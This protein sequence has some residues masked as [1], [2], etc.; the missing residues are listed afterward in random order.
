MGTGISKNQDMGGIPPGLTRKQSTGS[1]H[2]NGFKAQRLALLATVRM[3]GNSESLWPEPRSERHPWKKLLQEAESSVQ[4]QKEERGTVTDIENEP[5]FRSLMDGYISAKNMT[6]NSKEVWIFISSTFTDTILER[7]T[8]MED[9]YPYIRAYARKL[10]LDF[11]A[12]DF[13]WGIRKSLCN[14]HKAAEICLTEVARCRETSCGPSFV[15]ILGQKYGFRPIPPV[16]KQGEFEKIA[17]YIQRMAENDP[18]DDEALQLI[19]KWY[20]LDQNANEPEYVLQPIGELLP[21]FYKDDQAAGDEWNRISS[22]IQR[23]LFAAIRGAGLDPETVHL[24]TM[25]ITEGEIVEGLEDIPD[26]DKSKCFVFNRVLTNFDERHSNAAKY[27]DYQNGSVDVD[28]QNRLGKMRDYINAEI[29]A[30]NIH[31]YNLKFLPTQDDMAADNQN[32]KSLQNFADQFCHFVISAIQKKAIESDAV[33]DH[34]IYSEV[35]NHTLFSRERAESFVGREDILDVIHKAV[36]RSQV[37]VVYG[38]GGCGKTSL[39]CK[40]FHQTVSQWE[41]D[42]KRPFLIMRLIGTTPKSSNIRDL[43]RSVCQQLLYCFNMKEAIPVDFKSLQLYF[44]SLL[45]RVPD[46]RDLYVFLDSL[47]QLSNDNNAL[48]LEWMPKD[49]P[50]NVRLVLSVR[51]EVG[52]CLAAAKSQAEESIK[53]LPLGEKDK[54]DLLEL[55]LKKRGRKLTFVQKTHILNSNNPTALYIRLV[56]D[57][58]AN[59]RSYT[60]ISNCNLATTTAGLI[61]QFF[62]ELEV[63]HGETFVR[64]ALGYLTASKDGLSAGELLDVLSCDDVVLDDVFEFHIPPIRRVPPLLWTR[65]RVDLGPYLVEGGSETVVLYRWHHRLFH[66]AAYTRYVAYSA[67]FLH[68]SLANY[69]MSRWSDTPKPYHDK[70]TKSVQVAYRRVQPQPLFLDDGPSENK[71]R[72]Y[73]VRKLSEL[74]THLIRGAMWGEAEEVFTCIPWIEAKCHCE[75]IHQLLIELD[76]ASKMCPKRTRFRDIYKMIRANTSI[77][78]DHPELVCQQA[79]NEPDKSSCV[80]V[81][82]SYLKTNS[83]QMFCLVNLSKSQSPNPE[84]MTLPHPAPVT[85]VTF[86]KDG[87]HVATASSDGIVRAWIVTS[88]ILEIAHEAEA[89]RLIWPGHCLWLGVL[90]PGGI[91]L[92]GLGNSAAYA[93]G[94]VFKSIPIELDATARAF[95]PKNNKHLFVY[96]MGRLYIYNINTGAVIQKKEMRCRPSTVAFAPNGKLMAIAYRAIYLWDITKEERGKCSRQEGDKDFNNAMLAS[97]ATARG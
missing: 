33:N 76:E 85:A 48:D 14:E 69:F 47:D 40:V 53:V 60:P 91:K 80:T 9:V 44:A 31:R 58:A 24:L 6:K 55:L 21:N 62:S 82:R 11:N 87:S 4:R 64:S 38:N 50:E 29:P 97:L 34:A 35:L 68:Q 89:L 52:S 92:V 70:V 84:V 7:D 78:Q 77:L 81:A 45:Q 22:V 25:S 63:K 15:A 61:E 66:E 65:L 73:N 39:L 32:H 23:S 12:V 54:V 71:Q 27:L 94:Q 18:K 67:P 56:S 59:W 36:K 37:V 28:A 20:K 79:L 93:K 42:K 95:V 26:N 41:D 74:P 16:I 10:G 75:E 96:M 51:S 3:K 5:T 17:A 72:K 1:N 88:G 2:W 8:L 43:L 90:T 83:A 46:R 19:N 49:I 86:S 30:S 13:R 57:V